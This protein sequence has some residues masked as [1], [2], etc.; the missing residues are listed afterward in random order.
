MSES[1]AADRRLT[2]PTQ[3]ADA[4]HVYPLTDEHSPHPTSVR[5]PTKPRPP[6]VKDKKE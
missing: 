5:P 3:A 4:H 2:G 6:Q 1:D